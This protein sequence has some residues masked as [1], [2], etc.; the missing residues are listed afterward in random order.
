MASKR[1][2]KELQVRLAYAS[3]KIGIGLFYILRMA[4]SWPHPLAWSLALAIFFCS[5]AALNTFSLFRRTF[6]R[7]HLLHAV[8][9]QRAMISSTGR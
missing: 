4:A 3:K 7:I 2:Q 8:L 9:D 5:I 1:I 6:K